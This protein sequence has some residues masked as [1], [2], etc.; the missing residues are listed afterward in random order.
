MNSVV[1]A[2][3]TKAIQENLNVVNQGRSVVESISRSWY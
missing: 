2:S 1:L 3:N